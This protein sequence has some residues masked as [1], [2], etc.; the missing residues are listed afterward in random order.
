L[1]EGAEISFEAV[2][3]A[4]M[5]VKSGKSRFTLATLA[6]DEFPALSGVQA[7]VHLKLKHKDLRGLIEKVSCAMAQQDVSYY[8]K[9]MLLHI[10]ANWVR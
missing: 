4:R 7:D 1:P 5:T 8:L 6:A 10:S 9:G 3:D 2:D